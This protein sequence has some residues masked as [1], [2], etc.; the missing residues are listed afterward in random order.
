MTDALTVAVCETLLREEYDR[1][2]NAL[3]GFLKRPFDRVW[4]A[5]R[6]DFDKPMDRTVGQ[7][8]EDELRRYYAGFIADIAATDLSEKAEEWKRRGRLH[9]S[10]LGMAVEDRLGPPSEGEHFEINAAGVVS[11][12]ACGSKASETPPP[13]EALRDLVAALKKTLGGEVSVS[14]EKARGDAVDG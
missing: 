9:G 5:V 14:V 1:A 11:I 8:T 3:P 10:V 2:A 7:L 13:P 12:C 4:A 6:K